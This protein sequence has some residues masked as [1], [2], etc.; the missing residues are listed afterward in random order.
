MKLEST[1]K[2]L[3]K[4]KESFFNL[5]SGDVVSM[6]LLK[7]GLFCYYRNYYRGGW[8]IDS[9]YLEKSNLRGTFKYS[10][11]NSNFRY[12]VNTARDYAYIPE[13]YFDLKLI[14]YKNFDWITRLCN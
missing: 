14:E 6:E 8:Q 12:A 5:K 7:K 11:S 9:F 10:N 1:L 4:T 13:N 2:N 3:Q